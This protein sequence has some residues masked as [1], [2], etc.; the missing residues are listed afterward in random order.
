MEVVRRKKKKAQ[1]QQ[2][3]QNTHQSSYLNCCQTT[4]NPRGKSDFLS[5]Y[6][7]EAETHHQ[8]RLWVQRSIKPGQTL[9]EIANGIEDSVGRLVGHDDLFE[10][11]ANIAG[12]GYPTGVNLDDVAAHYIPNAGCKTLLQQNNV[13]KVDIGVHV[14]GRIVDSAFT[15]ACNPMYDN[16]FAAGKDAPNTGVREA[17]I[18]VR[19]GELGKYIL[20]TME[21]YECEI[22]GTTYPIKPIGNMIG[23]TIVQYGMLPTNSVPTVKKTNDNTKTEV[24]DVFY[25]LRPSAALVKGGATRRSWKELLIKLGSV[26]VNLYEAFRNGNFT[27]G[28]E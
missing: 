10:S 28:Q 6:R 20:E 21:S 9:T 22:D 18:D 19:L 14:N 23:H 11:D 4:G 2:S 5:D 13:M 3:K 12:M 26:A 8:I 7:Q 24:G 25:H 17:E 16:L 1:F 15:M 27:R